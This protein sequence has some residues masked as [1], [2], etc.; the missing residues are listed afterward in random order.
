[1]FCMLGQRSRKFSSRLKAVEMEGN[2]NRRATC[3]LEAIEPRSALG[4]AHLHAN[5]QAHATSQARGMREPERVDEHR[6]P[7]A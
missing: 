6:G 3:T 5:S 4:I 2:G 7:N 1:M